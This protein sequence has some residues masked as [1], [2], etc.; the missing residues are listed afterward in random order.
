MPGLGEPALVV[1]K[2]FYGLIVFLVNNCLERLTHLSFGDGSCPALP[3]LGRNPLLEIFL[4]E[5]L[6]CPPNPACVYQSFGQGT[7]SEFAHRPLV[8]TQEPPGRVSR[9]PT[10][11]LLQPVV[12]R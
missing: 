10:A 1:E 5:V 6:F 12:V 11:C 3:W 8:R 4:C 7:G 2:L 9:W